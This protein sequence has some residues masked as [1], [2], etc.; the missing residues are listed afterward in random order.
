MLNLLYNCSIRAYSFLIKGTGPFHPK[1]K[2]WVKGR[3]G[4]LEQFKQLRQEHENWSW[5]HCSSLGEYEDCCEIMLEIARRTPENKIL[6]TF[7][8]PS[9]YE[10]LKGSTDVDYVMYLPIDV[11]SNVSAFLDVLQPSVVI[12]GR[13]ELWLNYLFELK[14]RQI[15]L[16]LVSLKMNP[17]SGFLK[18]PAF[19]LYKKG[20]RC[21][22]HIYCQ[23]QLTADLLQNKCGMLQSTVIGNTRFERIYK[24]TLSSNDFPEIR[25]FTKDGFTVIAGSYLPKDLKVIQAVIP[26]LSALNCRWILVPHE[27]NH[28]AIQQLLERFPTISVNY[29]QRNLLN[30]DHRILIVDHVGSLKH[31]YRY[32]NLA[33]VGGG[34][35]RIGIHNIIE[36]AV[37][38]L[39]TL[40]GPNHRDYKEALDLISLKAA[41]VFRNSSELLTFISDRIQVSSSRENE[42]KEIIQY[43]QNHLPDSKA[44]SEH[45]LAQYH[46]SSRKIKQ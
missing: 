31:L 21:F 16:F 9:G 40:F 6:L 38:G 41:F 3:K 1:A 26:A 34:F 14:K 10:A 32:A 4:G 45:L 24:E 29:S 11:T 42:R 36:P 22:T 19:Q 17:K 39:V 25:N 12:F 18:Q 30:P 7:F 20:F 15:P 28:A 37:Y 43:V 33:I 13:S 23:D 46:Q 8:S 35:N 5:F 44:I 2:L 27:V